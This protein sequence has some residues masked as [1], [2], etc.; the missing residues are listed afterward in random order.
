MASN[1]GHGAKHII[2]GFGMIASSFAE[3]CVEI[4][5]VSAGENEVL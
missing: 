1:S 4:N 3:R 2:H 5:G